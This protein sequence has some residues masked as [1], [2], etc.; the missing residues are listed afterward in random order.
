MK[1]YSANRSRPIE[2]EF[3]TCENDTIDIHEDGSS[4]IEDRVCEGY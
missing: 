1:I 4:I 2:V 3:I